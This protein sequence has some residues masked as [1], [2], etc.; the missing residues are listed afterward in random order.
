[1][2]H[3]INQIKGIILD[4][5]LACADWNVAGIVPIGDIH[6]RI[7]QQ[8]GN[9]RTQ[10]GGI[11]PRHRRNQQNLARHRVTAAHGKVDQVAKGLFDHSRHINQ[12]VLP[13]RPHDRTNAPIRFGVHPAK[14]AL[15]HLSP[16]RCHGDQRVHRQGKGRIAGHSPRRSTGPLGGVAKAFHPVVGGHILHL[17]SL[18]SVSGRIN[19]VWRWTRFDVMLHSGENRDES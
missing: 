16:G 1:M 2:T 8:A 9:R 19:A 10:Q 5:K 18:R 14:A 4:I 12:M 6:I 13:S 17:V 15:G 3:K 11:M 7:G